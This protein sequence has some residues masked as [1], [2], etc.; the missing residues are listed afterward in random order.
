MG[1]KLCKYEVTWGEVRVSKIWQGK[2]RWGGSE[3]TSW[4]GWDTFRGRYDDVKLSQISCGMRWETDETGQLRWGGT[5]WDKIQ[6]KWHKMRLENISDKQ[7]SHWMR[8]QCFDV[9]VMFSVTNYSRVV[10]ISPSLS[11]VN[12]L[13][14]SKSC[15]Y[16]SCQTKQPIWLCLWDIL[17]NILHYF[18]T[19]DRP[20]D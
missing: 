19:V 5:R 15:I 11:C 3:K 1:E 16:E 4:N 17:M 6:G 12:I 7:K 14:F 20:N 8:L 10:K 18:L 13:W 2:T 9:F